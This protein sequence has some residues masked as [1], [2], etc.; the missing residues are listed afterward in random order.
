MIELRNTAYF[1]TTKDS[2]SKYKNNY[3]VASGS[4]CAK[5]GRKCLKAKRYG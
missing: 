5:P 3:I 1:I 2:Y 4:F